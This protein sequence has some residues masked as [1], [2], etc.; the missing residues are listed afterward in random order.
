MNRFVG[1]HIDHPE[2]SARLKG[3]QSTVSLAI[4][5]GLKSGKLD[6]VPL[7]EDDLVD[8]IAQAASQLKIL[9]SLR[10]EGR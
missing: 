1:I 7:S 6:H 4:S 3:E 10:K 2:Y 9:R 5:R 8:L